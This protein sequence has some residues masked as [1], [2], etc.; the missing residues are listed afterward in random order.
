MMRDTV[1]YVGGSKGG[2]GK[3]MISLT[4]IQFLIDKYSD[5]KNIHL[6]ETDESNPD[7][8]RVYTGKIPVD[9][10]RLDE[11]ENGWLK[12]AD[13]IERSCNTLFVVNSAAR[14]NLGIAKHGAN[15]SA[16]LADG[17]IPYDLVTFFPINRQK[18]S[19]LLLCDY[20][21]A[22]TFGNVYAVRNTYFGGPDQFTLFKKFLDSEPI[23]EQRLSD[24]LDFPELSDIIS[25][26][27]YTGGKTIPETIPNL[28]AF[29]RQS[30]KSWREKVYKMF[31][32][33]GLFS[34]EFQERETTHK[35]SNPKT[36]LVKQEQAEE[37]QQ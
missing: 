4:L 26:E 16:I 29:A 30:F 15:L 1:F 19:V 18:D 33:T 32:S 12:M 5:T 17:T 10:A 8:G 13:I 35:K 9:T 20:L 28:G 2:V 3:S 11:E 37:E 23:L 14:S 31:E 27:F 6:I 36:E 22:I 7:V 25:D 34:N 21:K 24:V